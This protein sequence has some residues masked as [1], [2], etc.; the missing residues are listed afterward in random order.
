MIGSPQLGQIPGLTHLR[1]SCARRLFFLERDVRRLGAVPNCMGFPPKKTLQQYPFFQLVTCSFV[2]RRSRYEVK[3]NLA[4]PFG[5]LHE[6]SMVFVHF[7]DYPPQHSERVPNHLGF[8][9]CV[10]PVLKFFEILVSAFA[11]IEL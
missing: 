1:A 8:R 3:D 11:E 9:R 10:K 6:N 5:L 2:R 4:G 7:T